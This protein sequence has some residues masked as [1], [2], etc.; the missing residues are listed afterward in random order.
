[1]LSGS[2][3]NDCPPL[4]ATTV[5]LEDGSFTFTGLHP[6]VYDL[7]LPGASVSLG[8]VVAPTEFVRRVAD[9]CLIELL[10]VDGHGTPQRSSTVVFRR[11]PS[12][13]DRWSRTTMSVSIGGE[14]HE[15]LTEPGAEVEARLLREEDRP[16]PS[17]TMTT[18]SGVLRRVLHAELVPG[19]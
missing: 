12:G 11:R 1:V 15:F 4:E 18:A 8:Q 7:G 9:V 16:G 5:T 17:I 13:E 19:D 2:A 6:G 14:P 3:G 10:V